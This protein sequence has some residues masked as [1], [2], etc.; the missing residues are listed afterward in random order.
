MAS[1]SKWQRRY[2]EMSG[3]EAA[4][5]KSKN[6]F[7]LG[8]SLSAL[9]RYNGKGHRL[10]TAAVQMFVFANKI[11]KAEGYSFVRPCTG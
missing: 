7:P 5:K 11:A 10:C 6:K 9:F 3:K 2:F 4:Y 1:I 8:G